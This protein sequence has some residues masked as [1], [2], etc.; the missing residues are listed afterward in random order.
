MAVI[1]WF[2][3]I[4]ESNGFAVSHLHIE[5]WGHLGLFGQ[6]MAEARVVNLSVLETTIIG[7]GD[8]VGG[9]AG[10]DR[11]TLSGCC[12]TGVVVGHSGVG[13]LV[14]TCWGTVTGSYSTATVTGTA[15]IGGLVGGNCGL[16]SQCAGRGTV[17]GSQQA[18]GGLIGSNEW[19]GVANNCYATG[20]V[21][22][23]TLAGGLLG[24]N[25]GKIT[26][27]YSTGAV[28]G[29]P[30]IGGLVGQNQQEMARCFWDMVS[31]RQ[32]RQTDGVGK[33]TAEMQTASTFLDAG[34]DFVGETE[35]GTEDIWWINEGKDYPRLWWEFDD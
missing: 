12:S 15:S 30:T 21:A 16:V 18:I 13:G 14:G 27:C 20:D 5:G 22:G 11:G 23:G 3:G 33:A 34:W 8:C 9:L 7:S 10:L 4:F 31:S 19:N 17:A 29:S 24:I 6:V 35:N 28:A 25:W 2:E 32:V 26:A 1:P